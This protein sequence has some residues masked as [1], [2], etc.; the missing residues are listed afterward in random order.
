[1]D[2]QRSRRSW[3]ETPVAS[4][5]RWQYRKHARHMA[6][7]RSS[8][9][10]DCTS[11]S[12]FQQVKSLELI[13]RA[14]VDTDMRIASDSGSDVSHSAM[15]GCGLHQGDVGAQAGIRARY[16]GSDIEDH[17]VEPLAG[18]PARGVKMTVRKRKLAHNS[19]GNR[20]AWRPKQNQ[21]KSV[22]VPAYESLRELG[23][24]VSMEEATCHLNVVSDS[25]GNGGL[26]MC[27][28]G[29]LE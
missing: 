23:I 6:I 27:R 9:N 25:L 18:C 4:M 13:P 12:G 8:Q 7:I 15:Y 1:M 24:Q 14:V 29:G 17:I 3:K 19:Q 26:C 11:Q 21:V 5:S 10:Q 20:M 16:I 28:A 2:E 22:E